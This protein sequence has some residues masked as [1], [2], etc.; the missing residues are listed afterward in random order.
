MFDESF[1]DRWLECLEYIGEKHRAYAKSHFR[2]D[3]LIRRKEKGGR[4]NP[5]AYIFQTF[6]PPMDKTFVKH[7]T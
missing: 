3:N 5:R 6:Q 4:G 2:G 1:I 7:Q